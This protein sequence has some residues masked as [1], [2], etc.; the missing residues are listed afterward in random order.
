[1][2]LYFLYV[3]RTEML[4]WGGGGGDGFGHLAAN[5]AISQQT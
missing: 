1:M 3:I 2:K 5:N 4:Y